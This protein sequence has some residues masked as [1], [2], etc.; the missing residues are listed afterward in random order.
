[1]Y[2]LFV[3]HICELYTA[4]YIQLFYCHRQTGKRYVPVTDQTDSVFIAAYFV[5]AIVLG[6]GW[7]FVCR[8]HC[9]WN[10]S[11]GI[12]LDDWKGTEAG[13]V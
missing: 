12:C 4:H 7:Y 10:G 13:E 1:M 6:T 3:F 9:R 5:L 2:N 11:S 8:S